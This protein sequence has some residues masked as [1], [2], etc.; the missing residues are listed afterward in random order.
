MKIRNKLLKAF[1]SLLLT[2][3]TIGGVYFI[4]SLY[5]DWLDHSDTLNVRKFEYQGNDL[6]STEELQQMTGILDMHHMK[7]VSLTALD[8]CLRAN[9]FIEAV[10]VTRSYPGNIL[11]KIKEKQPIALLRVDKEMYC[12]DK[13]GM[14]LQSRPGRM[15][16]LPILSG[17]YKGGAQVGKQAE[18][19]LLSRSLNFLNLI[20]AE[21]PDMY[22][23][24]SE[25]VCGEDAKIVVYTN[26][27]GIPVKF[28]QDE[29][30]YKIQ[31]FDA[32]LQ[33]IE[34]ENSYSQI[35][36]IDL[37]YHGQVILGM[38]A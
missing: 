18:S 33:Q 26:Q 35:E 22:N 7:D 14:V 9:P 36:Y 21:R 31:C 32:I 19:P 13:N 30:L 23:E 2:V 1:V 17:E 24:I 37:R 27:G 25:I 34:N 10:K 16:N 29:Y 5:S 28:G 11:M 20:I 8:S 12:V 38:R 4:F 3:T 6:L 15:Y